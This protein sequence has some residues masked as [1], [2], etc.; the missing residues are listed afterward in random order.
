MEDKLIKGLLIVSSGIV[1]LKT[2]KAVR[3]YRLQREL[4]EEVEEE[5]TDEK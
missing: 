2:I 3:Y 4:Y 5:A 1:A